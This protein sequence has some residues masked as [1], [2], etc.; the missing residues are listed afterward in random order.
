MNSDSVS[1]DHGK[2]RIML[3]LSAAALALAIFAASLGGSVL[4][5]NA[6]KPADGEKNNKVQL[7]INDDFKFDALRSNSWG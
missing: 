7:E 3:G 1:W 4:S 5:I 2:R 6:A